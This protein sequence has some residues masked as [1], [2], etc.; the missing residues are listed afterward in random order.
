MST[1]ETTERYSVP[2]SVRRSLLN[3]SRRDRQ[4]FDNIMLLVWCECKAC[5]KRLPSIDDWADCE[6]PCY[7]TGRG[8]EI[9]HELGM[10]FNT[11]RRKLSRKELEAVQKFI[12]THEFSDLLQA[13]RELADD[14]VNSC[15][16]S[17]LNVIDEISGAGRRL[18]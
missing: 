15:V 7:S 5:R 9:D 4:F 13:V 12:E 14:L 10:A 8:A 16:A 18:V 3:K 6:L 2:E 11:P 17:A 1:D